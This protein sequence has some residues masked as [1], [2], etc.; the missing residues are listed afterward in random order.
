L[1]GTQATTGAPWRIVLTDEIRRRLSGGDAPSDWVSLGV[2][3][4]RLGLSK[5][6]VASLVKSGKLKAM[7]TSVGNRQ[8][9]RID[10][11]SA[12]CPA[13]EALVTL[14]VAPTNGRL[15]VLSTDTP[16]AIPDSPAPGVAS[17]ILVAGDRRITDLSVTVVID[18]SWIG[19]LLVTLT[20]PRSFSKVLHTRTGRDADNIHQTYSVPE[21]VG[22]SSPWPP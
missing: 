15:V 2:A 10:L 20:G 1:V 18:H 8:C 11:S 3:A 14:T 9:W 7:R 12:D 5:S 17:H 21:A 19:D 6:H 13:A 16:I 22:R 4:R